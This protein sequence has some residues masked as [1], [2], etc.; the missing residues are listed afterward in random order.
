MPS[1]LEAVGQRALW[2]LPYAQATSWSD[3]GLTL[4]SEDYHVSGT[5]Q[6]PS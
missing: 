6:A 4:K 2:P 5:R 1:A 3:V